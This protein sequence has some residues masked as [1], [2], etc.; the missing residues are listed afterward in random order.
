MAIKIPKD[1]PPGARVHGVKRPRIE[2][3]EQIEKR[4][5]RQNLAA[6]KKRAEKLE[7]QKAEGYFESLGKKLD[8]E[9][10]ESYFISLVGSHSATYRKGLWINNP[11]NYPGREHIDIKKLGKIWFKT[12]HAWLNY[13]EKKKQYENTKPLRLSTHA[14]CDYLFLYL[15]WWMEIHP[16]REIE[17]PKS[18]K[19]F[20]RFLFVNRVTVGDGDEINQ[21]LPK[22]FLDL[23][24][25]RK[26]TPDSKNRVILHLEKYFNFVISAFEDDEDITFNQM[27]SPFKRGT[28]FYKVKKRTKTNKEPFYE[29]IYP[30]LVHYSQCVEAFG[31]IF[32]NWLMR[33]IF[34]HITICRLMALSARTLVMSL[35]SDL[36]AKFTRLTGFQMSLISKIEIS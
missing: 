17:Y 30:Y 34:L 31:S 11:T 13:L 32:C 27:T 25:K 22:T 1:L 7:Q 6:A 23:L 35:T 24:A 12:F 14:L 36:E 10:C 21:A 2:T 19:D 26:V 16:D 18:P 9:S 15:P 4:K 5:Q 33:K 8:D 3:P 28:D 20:Q 29:N